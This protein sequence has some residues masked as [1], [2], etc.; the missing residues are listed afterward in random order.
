MGLWKDKTP[1]EKAEELTESFEDSQ[2]RAAER[3]SGSPAKLPGSDE[4]DDSKGNVST[5]GGT[6]KHRESTWRRKKS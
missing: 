2:R 6:M 1:E 3:Q 4:P 5:S